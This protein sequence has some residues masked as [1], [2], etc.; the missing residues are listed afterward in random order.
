MKSYAEL[1]KAFIEKKLHP[2]DLKQ[3]VAKHLNLLLEP[4]QKKLS[5]NKTAQKLAEEIKT[6][7]VTR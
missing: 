2:M 6:F 1:E 5:V 7:E 4:V 3:S